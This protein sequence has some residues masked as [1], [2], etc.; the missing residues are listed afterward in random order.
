MVENELNPDTQAVIES[1]KSSTQLVKYG[2]LAWMLFALDMYLHL[3]NIDDFAAEALTE[4]PN[5]KSIDICHIDIEEGYILIGQSYFSD[6]WGKSEAKVNKARDLNT[7]ISWIF[8]GDID[9][10]PTL[11]RSKAIEI[12]R[13]VFAGEIRRIELLFVNNCIESTN[14]A[15]ELKSVANM[16]KGACIVLGGSDAERIV[17]SHQELGLTTIQEL[18]RSRDSDIMVDRWFTLPRSN[19]I[20]ESTDR[21]E[22]LVTTIQGSWIRMLYDE[23]GDRLF[24]ANFRDYLGIVQR[25]GNINFEIQDTVESEPRNFWVYNNGI[26]AITHELVITDSE[27]RLKGISIVNGAQTSGALGDSPL[28]SA[29]ET[30]VI[31]RIVKCKDKGLI[32]NII[33]FNNTQNEIRPADRRSKDQRQRRLREQFEKYGITYLH[34]RDASSRNVRGAITSATIAS[35]LCAF[36]GDMQTAYRNSK[37]IFNTDSVYD[38]VF[39]HELGAEH[40][41]LVVTL[42][43]AITAFTLRLKLRVVQ[44]E[45]TSIETEQYEILRFS[46]SKHFVLQL[47]GACAEEIMGMRI[48]DRYKW[49]VKPEFMTIDNEQLI[50]AWTEVLQL[51]IPQT[52]S[53]IFAQQKSAYDI[54]RSTDD[55]RR[56][57]SQLKANLASLRTVMAPIFVP[58][59]KCTEV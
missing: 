11:L 45:A 20:F 47:I 36:H 51:I 29:E 10:I 59:R 9:R 56:V 42:A 13:A 38:R 3:E 25:K 35:S 32:D 43:Q 46:M 52:A 31:C 41:Y 19:L 24:S 57:E 26:T 30:K 37:D 17:I 58:I 2:R 53:I 18:Y 7:A 5:D 27:I 44:E 21:W 33:R 23:Y 55:S 12:R 40:L 15:D 16:A 48:P 50:T 4:S 49:Q 39:R 1:F 6:T 22:G 28:E 14:V 8:S 54:A 34:R